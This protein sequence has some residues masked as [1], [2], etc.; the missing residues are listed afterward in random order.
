MSVEDSE[1][2]SGL[3]FVADFL[4]QFSKVLKISELPQYETLLALLEPTD[5]KG[6][7]SQVESLAEVYER[8][9]EVLLQVRFTHVYNRIRSGFSRL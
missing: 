2:T 4:S 3:V 9:L 1:A 5:A 8:L 6:R 7:E